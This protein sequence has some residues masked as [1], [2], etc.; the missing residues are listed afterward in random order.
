MGSFLASLPVVSGGRGMESTWEV[1]L[2][3]LTDWRGGEE[4]P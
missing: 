4:E 3:I 1:H 2:S